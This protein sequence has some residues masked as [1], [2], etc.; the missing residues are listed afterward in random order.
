LTE[1]THFFRVVYPK[2]TVYDARCGLHAKMVAIVAKQN[3]EQVEDID[4]ETFIIE[5]VHES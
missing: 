3:S 2:K 4:R 1:A 5:P